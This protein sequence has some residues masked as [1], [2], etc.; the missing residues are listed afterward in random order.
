RTDNLPEGLVTD[1]LGS[2]RRVLFTE[3]TA[4]SLDLPMYSVLFPK[5]SIRPKGTC[6]DVQDA[7]YGIHSTA[8][9]HRTEAFGLIDNDGIA[10]QAIIDFR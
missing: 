8:D 10:E 6:K 5:A 1:I 7:V 9:L 3:G 4:S 2:R